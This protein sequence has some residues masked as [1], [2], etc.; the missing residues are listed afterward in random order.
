MITTEDIQ[1]KKTKG[2]EEST[3]LNAGSLRTTRDSS[4]L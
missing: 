4:L 1:K 2:N 3:L